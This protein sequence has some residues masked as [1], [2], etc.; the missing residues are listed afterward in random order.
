MGLD[1]G[2]YVEDNEEYHDYSNGN[3]VVYRLLALF[4]V[5]KFVSWVEAYGDY[6]ANHY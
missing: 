6:L 2:Y 4:F 1:V 3:N 5:T